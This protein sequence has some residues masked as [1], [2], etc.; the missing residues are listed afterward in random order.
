MIKFEFTSPAV[1][2][3]ALLCGIGY[4]RVFAAF[5]NLIGRNVQHLVETRRLKRRNLLIAV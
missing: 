4:V 5:K 1:P 3:L 2:P